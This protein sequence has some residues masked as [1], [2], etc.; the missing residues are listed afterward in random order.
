MAELSGDFKIVK[1]RV[2]LVDLIGG[3]LTLTPKGKNYV[4]L[5]PWH[6]DNKPSLVVYPDRQTYR[7]WACNEGGDAYT[8]VQKREGLA[9]FEAFQTLASRVGHEI[10]SSE[11]ERQQWARKDELYQ[12]VAEAAD[13]Y[14]KLISTTESEKYLRERDVDIDFARDYKVG[15]AP[16]SWDYIKNLMS[17]HGN[18]KLAQ[19]GLV[20]EAKDKPGHFYDTFRGRIMFPIK[21]FTGRF[22]GFGG[23]TII[24]DPA[25]YVNTDDESPIYDK[26]KILYGMQEA[27]RAIR[28]S[29]EMIVTEGYL[30]MLLGHQHGVFNIVASC[31]TAFTDNQAEIVR[32]RFPDTR[33]I[34]GFDGDD[35]GKRAA[36]RAS[37][38]LIGRGN[39]DIALF[40]GGQDP[41]D[42]FHNHGKERFLEEIARST[43]L[44]EFYVDG[45][46]RGDDITVPERGIAFLQRIAPD[47]QNVPSELRG[48]YVGA[49]AGRMN[50]DRNSIES[51][52]FNIPYG[53]LNGDRMDS[54]ALAEFKLLQGLIHFPEARPQFE[55]R[56]TVD[57]FRSGE[58][59]AVYSLVIAGQ[60]SAGP[61]GLF[62]KTETDPTDAIMERYPGLDRSKVRRILF[63][64]G[65][66]VPI[67]LGLM[68]TAYATITAY[69]AAEI[70]FEK[71]REGRSLSGIEEIVDDL[72]DV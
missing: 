7:C 44:F 45:M 49:L 14:S 63:P 36:L 56:V 52:L 42:I 30:D 31:G 50:Q 70:I 26:S 53:D 33:V 34:L 43:P 46:A 21:D 4:A 10:Q 16:N 69:D 39:T 23:R 27:Q 35:P 38:K 64:S 20:R 68:E 9:F 59:R 37:S 11:E 6:D 48:I 5:C 2:D 22:V 13:I 18:K 15:F 65:E 54:R 71:H 40:S 24:D 28:G 60:I 19:V 32:R 41:A 67:S 47:F 17:G 55:E 25:K 51:V 72:E 3:S 12:I 61:G 62:E 58:R 1:D 29:G 66:R 57:T 8:F